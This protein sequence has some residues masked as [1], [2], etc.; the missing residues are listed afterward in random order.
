MSENAQPFVSKPTFGWGR[1][2]VETCR[3]YRPEKTKLLKA[4]VA[5]ARTQ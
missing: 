4:L 1:Y 2:P 3:V 5:G